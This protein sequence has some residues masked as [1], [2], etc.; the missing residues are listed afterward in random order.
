M[1]SADDI[2]SY[3]AAND[4]DYAYDYGSSTDWQKEVLRTGI[5]H[6]HNLSINGGS[7][8]TTYMASLNYNNREG[9]I[10][11]TNMYRIN[12][13]SLVSSKVLKDHL[14]LSAGLNAMYGKH[15]GVPMNNEG[16]S[17]L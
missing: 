17:V 1:A 6:N 16:G 11:G 4:I 13:R 10:K 14:D 9:V 5:S 2:R 15:E 7:K 12:F 8:K 3:V